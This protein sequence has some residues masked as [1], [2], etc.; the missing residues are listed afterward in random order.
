MCRAEK[1]FGDRLRFKEI[2]D[3]YIANFHQDIAQLNCLSPH[4]N[5]ALRKIF[6]KL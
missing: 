2:A 5:L 3:R 1:E 4:M 6:H